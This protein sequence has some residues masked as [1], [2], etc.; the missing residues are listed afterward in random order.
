V[1]AVIVIPKIEGQSEGKANVQSKFRMLFLDRELS[2]AHF[3][4]LVRV[5]CNQ[6]GAT[7][8]CSARLIVLADIS[9]PDM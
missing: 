2:L 5:W 6:I 4:R 7:F 8:F 9:T 3:V 1:S